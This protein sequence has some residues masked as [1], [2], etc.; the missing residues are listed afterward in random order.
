M[1]IQIKMKD[2]SIREFPAMEKKD[3]RFHQEVKYEGV[4]V[5]IQ[6]E[7]QRSVSI[8]ACDVIELRQ[9]PDGVEALEWTKS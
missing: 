3:R 2:G 4:F 8:P 7:W 9:I 5:I 6:D 1:L